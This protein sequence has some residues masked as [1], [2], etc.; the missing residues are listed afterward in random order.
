MPAP[1]AEVGQLLAVVVLQGYIVYQ[2][3]DVPD[4]ALAHEFLLL[5]FESGHELAVPLVK[6]EIVVAHGL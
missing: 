6:L 5:L 1:N 2:Y 4:S 3:K